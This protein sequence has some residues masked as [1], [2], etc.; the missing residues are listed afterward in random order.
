MQKPEKSGF[1]FADEKLLV[2]RSEVKLK[3][4]KPDTVL[5]HAVGKFVISP[6]LPFLPSLC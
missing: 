1:S 4:A 6:L 5:F 2:D 3:S